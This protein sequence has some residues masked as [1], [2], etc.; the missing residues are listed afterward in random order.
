[1]HERGEILPVQRWVGVFLLAM[2]GWWTLKGQCH[3]IF[4]L[5]LRSSK[6][7]QY[8]LNVRRVYLIFFLSCVA[9]KIQ[10]IFLLLRKLLNKSG[11]FTVSRFRISV[12]AYGFS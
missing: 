1:M 5:F 12:A 4:Y 6:L 8:F 10:N 7:N 3:D 11:D 9:V 2:V